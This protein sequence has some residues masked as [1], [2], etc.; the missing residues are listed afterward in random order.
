MHP[1]ATAKIVP[2][3]HHISEMCK[4]RTQHKKSHIRTFHWYRNWWPWMTVIG[5]MAV[6]LR[7]FADFTAHPPSENPGYAHVVLRKVTRDV[8]KNSLWW[9]RPL[10]F[11]L[12]VIVPIVHTYVWKTLRQRCTVYDANLLQ[13]NS[14]N[15]MMIEVKWSVS[16]NN[17][18]RVSNQSGLVNTAASGNLRIRLLMWLI[19]LMFYNW[20][21]PD[22]YCI[23]CI[24]L[25]KLICVT[26]YKPVKLEH[27]WLSFLLQ[28]L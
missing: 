11:W 8:G 28:Q 25:T 4:I 26:K 19:N 13:S 17:S 15:C 5:V 14:G 22:I 27:N 20:I 6:I 3:I 2:V 12:L 1:L 23:T 18:S 16:Q 10:D 21:Q 7:Y 9:R 24:I